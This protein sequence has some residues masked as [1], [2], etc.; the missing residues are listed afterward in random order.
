M[1]LENVVVLSILV[2]ITLIVLV[3]LLLPIGL[4]GDQLHFLEGDSA[5]PAKGDLVMSTTQCNVGNS[6]AY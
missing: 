5:C 4:I 1:R 2:C 6:K 3:S